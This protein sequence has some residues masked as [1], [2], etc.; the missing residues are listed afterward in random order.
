MDFTNAQIRM[1]NI[2]GG[3]GREAWL[4]SE[5]NSLFQDLGY[6]TEMEYQTGRGPADIYLPTRRTVVETKGYGQAGPDRPAPNGQTQEEQCERYIDGDNRQELFQIGLYSGVDLPWQAILTD[7]HQWWVWRWHTQA[8]GR[9]AEKYLYD[10]KSFVAGQA[11]EC[12]V[13]LRQL[14]LGAVGKPWVPVNP[15]GLF[16]PYLRDLEAFHER[17]RNT[18]GFQTKY[19]LWLDMLR[20]SGCAPDNDADGVDLFISHTLLITVARAVINTLQREEHQGL[21][22]TVMG[23]G[24]ASW[25]Q[26]RNQ[27]GPTHNAGVEWTKR[28]FDTAD[29][30]DWRRRARDVMRTLYQELIPAE[31]RKAFGEYYTP[32]WLAGMLAERIIDDEWMENA[33]DSYLVASQLPQGVGILDPSCGSGT[34]LF[35][36][37]RRILQSDALRRQ[38]VTAVR[39]ADFVARLVNGIDI[40]P[41]AVE[42][43]RATLLRALPAEPS[44]GVDALQVY[45]GDAL[46]YTRR[47]MDIANREDLP[48]YTIESPQGVEVRIPVGFTKNAAFG[49]NLRRMVSAANL[50]QPMPAGVFAGLDEKDTATLS[51][52]FEALGKICREEGNNVWAWYIA[53]TIAPSI[54]SERKVDRIL[55]N[56][57]WV[58]LGDIQVEE[59]RDDMEQLSRSLGLYVRRG[60]FDI[61]ALFVKRCR[62]NY[63][64]NGGNGKAA[65][66]LNRAA[67]TGSNWAPARTDQ[68]ENNKEFYDFSRIKDSPFTGASACAWVQDKKAN[69]GIV[70]YTLE[71]VNSRDKINV[72]D[73]WEPAISAKIAINIASE[74]LPAAPSE[75]VAGSRVPFSKGFNFEPI[76]L[77]QVADYRETEDGTVNFTTPRSRHEPYKGEGPQRGRVPA[78]WIRNVAPSRALLPFSNLI[79]K[80][81]GIIPVTESGEPD[82]ARETNPYWQM[83]E[84]IY[85]RYPTRGATTPKDLMGRI[86]YQ[87]KLLRQTANIQGNGGLTK[88]LYNES[89][90]ILRA[91]RVEPSVLVTHKVYHAILATADEAAYLT[92]IL[93]APCLQAAYQQSRKSDRDFETHFWRTVPIPRY[94]PQDAAHRAL[95]E[96]CGQ[97]EAIAEEVI[98]Q[99]PDNLGQI[100][101][102]DRVRE[103]LMEQGIAR[104][105]DREA[106]RILPEQAVHSYD[107]VHPHP[108]QAATI[109]NTGTADLI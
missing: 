89:G 51:A 104:R 101:L 39:Q 83:A 13:W 2:L 94:N 84:A 105:I 21:P 106:R 98:G 73:D 28:V 56:P 18:S 19:T 59:R 32:D 72:A 80:F 8:D 44:A 38:G 17:M 108:W 82:P 25:P 70:R 60:R 74:R 95:A 11:E 33:V 57:P 36:A 103:A 47:G 12:V 109:A 77:V 58:V 9:I 52:S 31:Q 29:A 107:D 10:E 20:G 46:I 67:L 64:V 1:S 79:D 93:N 48:F 26:D 3:R 86:N 7:G 69:N 16:Q 62:H 97:A 43:S 42:I 54:L 23:D 66:L 102:S 4:R 61:A 85:R 49:E 41:I 81:H 90:Q 68:K 45:Q 92:S 24:F 91:C 65:W 55:A 37:A 22:E 71:N 50:G 99:Q 40:H 63:L 35:H 76:C 14:T 53:N 100:A 27:F 6:D 75:Y 30:F 96:L 88:L 15:T 87:G 5:M 34:F 78:G